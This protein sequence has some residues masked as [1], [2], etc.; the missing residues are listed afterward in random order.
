MLQQPFNSYFG[1]KSGNG[2][3]QT[4][5]NNIPKC[6]VFI[7]AMVGNGGIVCNLNL[8]DLT[9]INDI[10]T[11][12]IGKYNIDRSYNIIKENLHYR[13]LIVKYNYLSHGAV[14]YFDPPYLKSTR[15]S[16]I[17]VYKFEWSVSD[18]EEFIS[19]AHKVESNC[20]ISHYPCPLYD[21]S[22]KNWNQITFQS[23]TRQGTATERIYF[24]YEVPTILQD[25]RYIGKNY[26]D[27]QRIKRKINREIKKL[28]SLPAVERNAIIE[29]INSM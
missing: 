12:I 25:Y 2:T 18:H 6:H 28:Q 7:D 21:E 13:D 23:I 29:A 17:N 8:P 26:I 27:R 19:L 22:F 5:I 3:Y 20:M 15:K 11:G 9:V 16:Q 1:G 4:I 10:D 24:N 14:F